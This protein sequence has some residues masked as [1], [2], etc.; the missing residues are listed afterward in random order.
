MEILIQFLFIVFKFFTSF[1]RAC[2]AWTCW[3]CSD[4]GVV[5]G[6][7]SMKAVLPRFYP[8]TT[9]WVRWSCLFKIYGSGPNVPAV[10]AENNL[11]MTRSFTQLKYVCITKRQFFQYSVYFQPLMIFISTWSLLSDWLDAR[12]PIKRWKSVLKRFPSSLM[13]T[14]SWEILPK[15]FAE[16]INKKM[17]F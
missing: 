11:K 17:Y 4:R 5:I 6:E 1:E 10:T 3:H 7:T 8:Q 12:V 9:W 13:F 15:F 14:S 2:Y 16:N